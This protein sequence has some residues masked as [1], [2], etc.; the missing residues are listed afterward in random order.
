MG[1][2]LRAAA[3]VAL[4]NAIPSAGLVGPFADQP[5]GIRCDSGVGFKPDCQAGRNDLGEKWQVKLEGY[6]RDG[7]E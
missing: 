2:S 1:H 5:G 3:G 6:E 7:C 4:R